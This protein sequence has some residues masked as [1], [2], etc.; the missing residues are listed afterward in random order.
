M[1]AMLLD[2]ICN[3][4]LLLRQRLIWSS[5]SALAD[6]R[7]NPPHP[8]QPQQVQQQLACAVMCL[9]SITQHLHLH[10]VPAAMHATET[11]QMHGV[12]M[13][14]SIAAPFYSNGVKVLLVAAGRTNAWS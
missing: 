10:V 5:T 2:C 13:V 8:A 11:V 6:K 12:W 14:I 9:N 3:H 4:N 7:P 1:L